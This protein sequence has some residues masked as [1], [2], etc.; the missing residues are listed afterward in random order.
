M[1]LMDLTPREYF[2][3]RYSVQINITYNFLESQQ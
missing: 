3:D 1:D 2:V